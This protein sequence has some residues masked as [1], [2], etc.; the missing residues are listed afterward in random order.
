[1][2]NYY[3]LKHLSNKLVNSI[4]HLNYHFSLSPHKDVWTA[5]LGDSKPLF[6][7]TLSSHPAETALFTE[8]YRSPKKNNVT[9]FFSALNGCK[10]VDINIADNDR[11]ISIHFESG[12][13]LLF[14]LF[15]SNPNLFLI[16]EN[17][18]LESFKNPDFYTGKTPPLPRP[19]SSSDK[20]V[21]EGLSPKKTI[22]T[23]NP[24]FPRHLIPAVVDHYNLES[25]TGYEIKE[26]IGQLT[27][28]M[29]DNPAFRVLTTGNLCLIPQEYLP[30][31]NIQTFDDINSAIRFAYYHTSVERRF[32]SRLARIKPAVTKRLH[33]LENLIEQLNHAGKGYERSEHYEQLGHILMANA[34]LGLND[35]RESITLPDYYN[36]N[37]DIEI[38]IKPT[39]S[40]AENAERYYNKSSSALRSIEES[41]R[42]LVQA[43]KEIIIVK[44]LMDSLETVKKIHELANWEKE[45]DHV[46]RKLGIISKQSSVESVPYRKFQIENYEIWLGKNAKSN[47]RL[48]SDAH[49]EDVWMHARG[50]SGSHLVVRMN[51]NKEMPPHPV[52]MK[53]ASLAAYHS[54]ARGS[55]LVPVIITKR[56]YV[57]KPKG[58]PPGSVRVQQE[59]V[60]LVKPQKD[61]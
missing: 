32:S 26:L 11:F 49:K 25:K 44:K 28:L 15:G 46:L 43:K 7:L 33:A 2:N 3:A 55:E 41:K 27:T 8:D 9:K 39:L 37:Q 6:R 14:Q 13:Q 52:L 61:I 54:K 58:S 36:D 48:T 24:K 18:I 5:Y 51:N 21:K 1:M 30:A 42:R 4:I 35:N 60:E 17:T 47:D 59:R 23:I 31:E 57:S 10:I 20:I 50:T 29:E 22:T 40:L 16:R 38:E 56:K 12:H 53:A 19:A 45:N 34:H